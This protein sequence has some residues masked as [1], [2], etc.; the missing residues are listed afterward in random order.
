ME[1]LSIEKEAVYRRLRKD[2]A[3]SFA[4]IEKIA[5]NYSISLDNIMENHSMEEIIFHLLDF[6]F[7]TISEAQMRYTQLCIDKVSTVKNDPDSEAGFAYNTLPLT[8]VNSKRHKQIYLFNLHKWMYQYGKYTVLPHFREITAS[9]E[10]LRFN[11][12]YRKAIMQTHYTYYIFD[13]KIFQ[14]LVNDILYFRRIKYMTAEEVEILKQELFAL[15]DYIEQ[16]ATYGVFE[17]GKKVDIYVTQMSIETSYNYI[18]SRDC[19]YSYIKLFNLNDIFSR[20]ANTIPQLKDW[21]QSLKKSSFKISVSN[22]MERIHYFERQ[23]NIV[24]TL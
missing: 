17:N 10:L 18:D 11:D 4:E 12:L 1:L 5:R 15:L 19:C 6:D 23:R 22:E 9:E 16:I 8:L 13:E 3:F 7:F 21:S 20:N 2:V 14:C 24:K